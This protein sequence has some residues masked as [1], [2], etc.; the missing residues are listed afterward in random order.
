MGRVEESKQ[1]TRIA[2]AQSFCANGILPESLTDLHSFDQAQIIE[3]LENKVMRIK[4]L[5]GM[6][7]L[8]CFT[9]IF[10]CS[11]EIESGGSGVQSIAVYDYK[12]HYACKDEGRDNAVA[13]I[14]EILETS[15]ASEPTDFFAISQLEK[16]R[17][18]LPQN[19]ESLG[20]FCDHAG[21]ERYA[22]VIGI[23]YDQEKWN[24]NGS[25]PLN[26]SG[27]ACPIPDDSPQPATCTYDAQTPCCAC[28]GNPQTPL[29]APGGGTIGDRA[30]AIG[31]FEDRTSNE[32][33]VIAAN[34]PHPVDNQGQR[35]CDLKTPIDCLL[36]PD[37][38]G[39]FGTENFVN[40]VS[41]LCSDVNRVIFLGDTNASNPSWTL[42]EMFP[43]GVLSETAE[44]NSEHFT[45]CF[46]SPLVNRFPTD[47]IGARG[48]SSILTK[49]GAESAGTPMTA[50]TVYDQGICPDST[51]PESYGFPCCGSPEEHAPLRSVIQFRSST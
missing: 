46:E 6:T 51:E 37:G 11:T 12:P 20:A 50:P 13:W 2:A 49:G 35:G 42:A 40:Q 32:I 3:E 30:F 36:N 21:S 43:T 48:A 41:R 27:N 44:S 7:L 45:C 5:A 22:D 18:E 39:I 25:Y 16:Q 33:C 1:L 15:S 17:I 26:L 34:L 19:Y 23:V 8:I 9:V 4:V 38:S 28:T 14:E 31:R 47:R 24:L 29:P 10:S